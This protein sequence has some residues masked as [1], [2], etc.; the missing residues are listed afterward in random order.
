MSDHLILSCF[1]GLDLLGLAFEMEWPDACLVQGPDVIWGRDIRQHHVPAG[2]FDGIIGGPPCQPF[3][4]LV[5]IVRANGYEPRHENLIPEFE[6]VISEARPAWFVMEEVE[7]APIPCVRGY[8]V[9]SKTVNNRWFG[10]EFGDLIGAEQNRVRRFS[11]GTRDGRGLHFDLAAFESPVFE[12]AVAASG[13]GRDVP[14]E[15]VRASDGTLRTKTSAMR[16]RGYQ[17][18]SGLKKALRLQ[19]LPETLLD[20]S[21]Y[22]LSGKFRLVGNG[23]PLPMGRAVARAVRR[24][25]GFAI[26]S[27]ASA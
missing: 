25:L 9:S 20:E 24:A 11:F 13:G 19:G 15:M 4:R 26:V 18:A 1:P 10:H 14:V 2:R 7:A 12:M 6:R 8:E 16:N 22:T 23:V 5:H 17:S 21:P 3:S 27:E